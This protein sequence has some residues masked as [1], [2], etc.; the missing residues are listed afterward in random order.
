MVGQE[1]SSIPHHVKG[2]DL[3]LSF[4]NP[5]TAEA[6]KY[7]ESHLPEFI[8]AARRLTVRVSERLHD[9]KQW[10]APP[11]LRRRIIAALDAE[12]RARIPTPRQPRRV[13][14]LFGWGALAAAATVAILVVATPGHSPELARPLVEQAIVG[15]ATDQ[16]MVNSNPARLGDWLQLQVGYDFEIPTISDASLIGGSV[17]NLNGVRTA[18]VRYE[19]NGEQL[20]YFAMPTAEVLGS[21]LTNEDVS[22]VSSDG[23]HIA[24][25][26][27]SGNARA[28]VSALDEKQVT[29]VAEECRKK[30]IASSL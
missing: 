1:S 9:L 13:W 14:P 24:T 3:C 11:L 28:L 25:W 20:T 16:A 19:L 10:T 26:V 27:E 29:A 2:K 4:R 21:A 8:A 18:A 15:L 7:S 17:A 6:V 30:A 12:D 23:Y 5:T 22:T